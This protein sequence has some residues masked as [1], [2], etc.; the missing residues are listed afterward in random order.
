MSPKDVKN[1][2]DAMDAVAKHMKDHH[3]GEL[4]DEEQKHGDDA[5][6]ENHMKEAEEQDAQDKA[7]GDDYKNHIESDDDE[8]FKNRQNAFSVQDNPVNLLSLM[9]MVTLLQTII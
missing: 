6:G 4:D 7:H 3:W 8:H 5:Y 9:I 2:Q 1:H